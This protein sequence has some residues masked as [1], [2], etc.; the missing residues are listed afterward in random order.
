MVFTRLELIFNGLGCNFEE[1]AKIKCEKFATFV[2][3]RNFTILRNVSNKWSGGNS[4]YPDLL[5]EIK[6]NKGISKVLSDNILG[7][8]D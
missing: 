4:N 1:I 2:Q 7:E 6:Y 8:K 3:T 5:N